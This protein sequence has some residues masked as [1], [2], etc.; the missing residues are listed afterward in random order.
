MTEQEIQAIRERWE[1]VTPWPWKYLE[2]GSSGLPPMIVQDRD[3]GAPAAWAVA[4]LMM[5]TNFEDYP[6][7]ASKSGPA[8]AHAPEDVFALLEEVER[9]QGVVQSIQRL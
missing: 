5:N 6:E 2:Q 8:I 1:K 4:R 7:E 3:R 9:L